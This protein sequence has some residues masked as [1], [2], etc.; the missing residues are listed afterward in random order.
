MCSC[1]KSFLIRDLLADVFD[2]V[3]CDK[4][5]NAANDRQ[6]QYIEISTNDE[7]KYN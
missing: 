3:N 6:Q 2:D 4:K 7:C 1:G 5:R